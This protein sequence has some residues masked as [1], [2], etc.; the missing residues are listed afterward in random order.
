MLAQ[1]KVGVELE[2]RGH[3]QVQHRVLETVLDIALTITVDGCGVGQFPVV[4]R[5]AGKGLF[6]I[7]LVFYIQM[8]FIDLATYNGV[9]ADERTLHI[10]QE[11]RRRGSAFIIAF[12]STVVAQIARLI[13]KRSIEANAKVFGQR[14]IGVETDVQTIH[15]VLLQCT[16]S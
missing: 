13:G 7:A 8:L 9:G 16:L 2:L 10:G 12:G 14:D 5:I 3:R 11:S 4:F 1:E 6:Q 15:I